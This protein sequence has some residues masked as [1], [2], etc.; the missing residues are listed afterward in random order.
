MECD[1]GRHNR[2]NRLASRSDH[3]DIETTY[4]ETKKARHQK[5]LRWTAAPQADRF[6]AVLRSDRPRCRPC[7]AHQYDMPGRRCRLTNAPGPSWP[8]ESV[9][10]SDRVMVCCASAGCAIIPRSGALPIH[11]MAST[12]IGHGFSFSYSTQRNKDSA[13]YRVQFRG[14]RSILAVGICFRYCPNMRF[15]PQQKQWLTVQNR[16]VPYFPS[17]PSRSSGA[18]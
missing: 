11:E 7:P 15:F 14:T 6:P 18:C 13:R 5:I 9:T 10:R 4:R 17:A 3:K 2:H 12:Q 16:T 1:S 8:A